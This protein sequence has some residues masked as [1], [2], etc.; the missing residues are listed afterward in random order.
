M[1]VPKKHHTKGSRN[2]RRMHIFIKSPGV[3][4]C[5]RCG[6]PIL[7]HRV[8]K[9]CG[10]YKGKMIVDVFA[11]LD[12]KEK[13]KKAKELKESKEQAGKELSMEDLSK[14]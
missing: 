4:K 2:Q 8:C 1:A 14:K 7:P 3:L 13:K 11:K 6:K 10:Y 12:K 9:E 5:P